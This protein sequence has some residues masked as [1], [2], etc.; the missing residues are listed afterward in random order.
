MEGESVS[1]GIYHQFGDYAYVQENPDLNPK[2]AVHYSISYDSVKDED[3]FRITLYNKRY[4]NLFLFEGNRVTNNG[5]GYARGSELFIKRN[6]NSYD[7]I[8]VYNFLSS[9]RKEEGILSLARSPYEIDHSFTAIFTLKRGYD[10]I[11]IRWSYASG[12]PY[13]PSLGNEWD[14]ERRIYKPIWGDPLSKRYPPYRRVDISGK[15][16]MKLAGRMFVLYIGIMNI[17]N[18][19]NTLRYEY[20]EDFS[21]QR[22]IGSIFSRT[23]FFGFYSPF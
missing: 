22:T 6:R 14:E 3:A 1:A 4:I 15:K 17:F 13:T 11:G 8:F 2:K 20:S 5:Y 7:L 21:S 9:K 19:K 10:S 16:V 23:F 18:H 12:L